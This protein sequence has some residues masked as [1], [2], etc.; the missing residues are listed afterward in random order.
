MNSSRIAIPGALESRTRK[1]LAWLRIS[2]YT[3]IAE[4][5][6]PF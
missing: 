1:N 2:R 4:G 3:P 5:V 6:C